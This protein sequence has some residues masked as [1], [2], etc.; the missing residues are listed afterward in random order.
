MI[1][2][3]EIRTL[4]V[5]NRGEIACRI[6]RTARAMGLRTV[7]VHSDPDADA[8]FVRLADVAVRLGGA[9]DAVAKATPVLEKMGKKIV[10]C[11]E[12]GAGQAAKICNNMIL[13]ISMIAV[14]EAFALAEQQEVGVIM[15]SQADI[16][17]LL[18]DERKECRLVL[19][20]E[21]RKQAWFIAPKQR[22]TMPASE[23]QTQLADYFKVCLAQIAPALERSHKA[24][25][26]HAQVYVII[27]GFAEQHVLKRVKSFGAKIGCETIQLP[28]RAHD[29]AVGYRT[30]NGITNTEC[31][32]ITHPFPAAN[33]PERLSSLI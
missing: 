19:G 4:L 3:R 33:L 30:G 5:A 1:E 9:A 32:R 2:P 16:R 18:Q 12:A 22:P 11:G 25:Y 27:V 21:P 24:P 14:G 28:E 7:A 15:G 8:T 29:R 26:V 17:G 20:Q 23:R 6:I 13:G 10:A 31:P